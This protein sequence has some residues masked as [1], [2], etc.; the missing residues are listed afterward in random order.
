MLTPQIR[1]ELRHIQVE[2]K[3]PLPAKLHEVRELPGTDKKWVFL[4]WQAIRDRLDEIAPEW[5]IDHSEIQYMNNDAICR[6]GI[7]ILGVRKEAIASVPIS[8]VSGKGKEMTRGSAADRLAA[9]AIKNAAETWGVGRYL[10]DQKFT[11]EYLWENKAQLSDQ[12]NGELQVL[13]RQYKISNGMMPLLPQ[14]PKSEGGMLEAISGVSPRKT[15]SDAQA[16]RLW[17]IASKE[18]HLSE[19]DVKAVFAEFKIEKTAEIAVADY[20]K[21]I[22]RLRAYAKF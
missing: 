5:L 6:C 11:I 8:L 13:I 1:E 2:L 7:T 14:K 18:L 22:E 17:A 19:N 20:D 4:P 15:I 21:V 9:E 16:K 12:M 3:K 10:D